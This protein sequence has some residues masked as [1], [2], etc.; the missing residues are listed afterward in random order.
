M[1]FPSPEAHTISESDNIAV[2]LLDMAYNTKL[3]F[4]THNKPEKVTV[5]RQMNGGFSI[6]TSVD[7]DIGSFQG[8]KGEFFVADAAIAN[9]SVHDHLFG[10]DSRV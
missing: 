2:T 6:N 3:S 5:T 4:M 9:Q 7:S 10:R 1:V 8:V